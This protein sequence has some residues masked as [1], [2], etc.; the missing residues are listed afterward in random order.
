MMH[1]SW[2]YLKETPEA[3]D[4]KVDLLIFVHPTWS[5]PLSAICERIS[6]EVSLRMRIAKQHGLAMFRELAHQTLSSQIRDSKSD[7]TS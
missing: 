5:G 1:A 7:P 3:Q 4:R 6:L 2:N